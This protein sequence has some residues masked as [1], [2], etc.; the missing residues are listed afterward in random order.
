MSADRVGGRLG[1]LGPFFIRP[2]IRKCCCHSH[3]IQTPDSTDRTRQPYSIRQQ[4]PW[5][6]VSQVQDSKVCFRPHRGK[7]SNHQRYGRSIASPSNKVRVSGDKYVR[8]DSLGIPAFSSLMPRDRI[9]GNAAVSA[10]IAP[11]AAQMMGFSAIGT[12]S[13]RNVP[14]AVRLLMERRVDVDLRFHD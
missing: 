13:A 10:G 14:P 11:S 8:I 4:G 12:K 9:H 3:P 5:P 1:L 7:L 2:D 6:E